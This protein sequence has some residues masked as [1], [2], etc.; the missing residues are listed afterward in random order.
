[1]FLVC[2]KEALGN[3]TGFLLGHYKVQ[4]SPNI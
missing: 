3:V 2:V 1:M 4:I